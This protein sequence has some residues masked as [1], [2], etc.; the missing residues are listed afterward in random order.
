[1]EQK[2]PYK[3]LIVDDHRAVLDGTLYVLRQEYPEAIALTA[4]TARQALERLECEK[5]DLVILDL[6]LPDT[7]GQDAEFETGIRLLQ[8][9]MKQYPTLN[10]TILSS[11]VHKLI[12]I[13]DSI[14]SH[15][16][17]FT[18]ARKADENLLA[19]IRGA[20]DG[21]AHTREIR[22]SADSPS[23]LEFKSEWLTVLD[24]AFKEELTDK[25]I[26]KK[27]SV[28]DR[29][30]RHYWTKIYDALDIFPEDAREQEKNLRLR[31]SNC[32][33]RE[34]LID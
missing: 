29:T 18:V 28:A 31:V 6:S 19:R 5:F 16:G 21:F 4:K 3:F 34:G 33:R 12:R 1:M 22:R 14:D 24:L 15:E 17:G 25:A 27:M 2:K 26:A 32:A 7:I 8:N 20:L 9:L 30:V 13:K 11:A 23:T 10:L